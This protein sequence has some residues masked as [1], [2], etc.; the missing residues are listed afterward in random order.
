MGL[1]I[2]DLNFKTDIEI[3]GKLI[4]QS[5]SL[6]YLFVIFQQ[7]LYE[8]KENYSL[9]DSQDIFLL[10]FL[11]L[12]TSFISLIGQNVF[13]DVLIKF[14]EFY[15]LLGKIQNEQNMTNESNQ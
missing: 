15:Q 7:A 8:I 10:K 12:S 13:E 2:P 4:S 5:K 11:A 3:L 9:I 6:K 1:L 14:Q